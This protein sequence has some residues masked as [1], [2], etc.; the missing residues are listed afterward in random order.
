MII[1]YFLS[2]LFALGYYFFY[3]NDVIIASLFAC[4]SIVLSIRNIIV[5]N[6]GRFS[7]SSAFISYTI[8]T[9]FGLILPY[10]LIDESVVD[11][12][13]SWTISFLESS[14]LA[15]SIMLGSIAI[16]CY[17][18][19]R[20][21]SVKVYKENVNHLQL[22]SVVKDK[23]LKWF[24]YL[25]LIIVFSFFLYH[26][27]TGGMLL[28][29]T[30]EM[31]LDSSAY[32]SVYYPYIL[33]LFYVATLYLAASDKI[34]YSKFGWLLWFV[35]VTIFAL[36]GNKG[37]FLYVLLA[38]FGL[39]GMLGYKMTFKMVASVGA[40]VF[41][42]IPSITTLRSIGIVS[43]LSSVGFDPFGA[44]TEMGFQIRTTIY[45]LDEI[46]MGRIVFLD[47][48]SYWRP[49][50]NIFIPFIPH[51]TA[52]DFL[53]ELFPGYGYNQ[54]IESY[55]NFGI[56]GVVVFFCLSGYLLAKYERIANSTSGLA[57]LG[58]ITT[59][60]INAARNYFSFVPGQILIVSL[61]FIFYKRLKD[62]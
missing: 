18:F 49:I 36:N 57:Y 4:L 23:I 17:E 59:V 12:Y 42:V 30:Y 28:F 43:N 27:L 61:L 22:G 35:I 40:I 38:V 26:I 60:M 37:E 14:N 52:T 45:T 41:I 32:H 39:R 53:R 62:K 29:S 47:G 16:L 56:C 24:S 3:D 6:N 54:V 11:G 50:V 51:T 34:K 48:E 19:S 44:L 58:T 31:F 2:L 7:F 21:L 13:P 10:L 55:L 33:I 20:L 5:T 9:Q 15:P 8:C 1:I 46:D 25:L